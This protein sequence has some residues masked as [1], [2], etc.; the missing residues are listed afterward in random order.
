[1]DVRL[2]FDPDV[3][4]VVDMSAGG[5]VN[6]LPV[7]DSTGFTTPF[8]ADYTVRNIVDNF[9][10]TIW[11]AASS[12]QPTLAAEGSGHVAKFQ[13]RAKS[14]GDPNFAFTYIKLS[15]PTGIEIPATGVIDGAV[16]A[17][18]VV[19]TLGISRL[20]A[21]TVQ[22]SWPAVSTGLVTKYHLY[23]SATPYFYA[24]GISPQV[25]TSVTN[26]GTG[27]LT[28]NDAVLGNVA[29]NYFYT[30]R[31]ECTVPGSGGGILSAPSDQVGKF[32]YELFETTGTDFSWIGLVLEVSPVIDTAA[33]LANHI[34][35]NSTGSVT[36]KTISRWNPTSQNFTTYIN[37]F[38]FSGSFTTILKNAYR[39]EVDLPSISTGNVIWAQVGKLPT[40]T[41]DTYTLHET[42]GTDYTWVLQPLDLTSVTSANALASHIVNNASGPVGV[43]SVSRW[44]GTSQN[45]TIYNP[46]QPFGNYTTRFG[47]PYRIEVN[48]NIGLTVTWP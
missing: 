2:S 31:A 40:I 20:D 23:R 32:E 25:V 5:A 29:T 1:V 7:V 8:K 24:N 17:S 47:Y 48:V 22:L 37:T 3:I 45:L 35:A 42:S 41:Q 16:T 44:N 26:T 27:T 38:P 21:G 36:V 34:Q 6:I 12:T 33:K 4:E 39:I 43:L 14:N 46:Q 18:T 28:V 30:L 9:R 15:N 19:P 11:Y 13:V 10:G